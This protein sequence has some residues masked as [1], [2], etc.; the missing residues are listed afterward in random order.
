[1]QAIES[2]WKEFFNQFAPY[3][4]TE[5]ELVDDPLNELYP[6]ITFS[7]QMGDY[8][9]QTLTTFQVWTWSHNN[10]QLWEVCNKISNS[11]QV[12]SG[13]SITIPGRIFYE[14]RN[15]DTGNWI[16]FDI[17]EFQNIADMLAPNPVEWKKIELNSA[18]AIEIWR[19]NPFLTPSPKD[20]PL[21]RVQYGTLICRYLNIK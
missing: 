20:N 3:V 2:A 12:E 19:G 10:S 7:Y 11:I 14:Y 21:S 6:R 1:M 13:A 9:N 8:F 5:G 16:E 17:D 4:Y 18:G 15:P